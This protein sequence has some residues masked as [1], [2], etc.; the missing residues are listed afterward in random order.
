MASFYVN[1]PDELEDDDKVNISNLH[2]TVTHLIKALNYGLGNL[3]AENF[4]DD[5]ADAIENIS[6]GED[7]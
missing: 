4:S 5:I 3:D 2:A 1:F 6:K 7:E